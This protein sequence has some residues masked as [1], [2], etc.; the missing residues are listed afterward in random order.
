MKQI[1]I[2]VLTLLIFLG[3]SDDLISVIRN[4]DAEIA[5]EVTWAAV[6]LNNI[7]AAIR[8]YRY[9]RGE[10]PDLIKQLENGLWHLEKFGKWDYDDSLEPNYFENNPVYNWWNFRFEFT[11]NVISKVIAVS[12]AE[13]IDGIGMELSYSLSNAEYNGYGEELINPSILTFLME[14]YVNPTFV[15]V[16]GEKYDPQEALLMYNTVRQVN[17]ATLTTM[18]ILHG[19]RMYVQDYGEEPESVILLFESEYMDMPQPTSLWWDFNFIRSDKITHLEA[20]SSDEMCLG[21]RNSLV[22]NISTG[23]FEGPLLVYISA[24]MRVLLTQL[25]AYL[26]YING[27]RPSDPEVPYKGIIGEIYKEY[28]KTDK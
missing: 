14:I 12:T 26:L 6:E 18:S 15:L 10:D 2:A 11:E 21:A 27:A 5:R 28:I 19:L 17:W 16:P 7:V 1:I 4:P 22:Y 3:C 13:M 9:E 20:I 25:P 23:E 24:Y 8:F